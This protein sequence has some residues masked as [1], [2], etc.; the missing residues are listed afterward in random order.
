MAVGDGLGKTYEYNLW[1]NGKWDRTSDQN[2]G[3]WV[4]Q[5]DLII[6][7]FGQIEG[8]TWNSGK[9]VGRR[10][11]QKRI[12]NPSY[13]ECIEPNWKPASKMLAKGSYA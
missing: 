6:I 4:R 8:D 13:Y 5:D 3:S 10:V 11:Y 12:G 9:S 7:N 2:K 1:S